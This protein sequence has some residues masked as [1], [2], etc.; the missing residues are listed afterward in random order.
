MTGWR[1]RFWKAAGVV[2]AVL[3]ASLIALSFAMMLYGLF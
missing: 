3:I 2:H 1:G